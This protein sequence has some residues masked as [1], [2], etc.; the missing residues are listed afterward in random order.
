MFNTKLTLVSHALCPFVQ[1]A[2]IALSEKNVPFD[3]ISIDLDNK[4]DWFLAISPLG[5]VPL[6]KVERAD[7]TEAVIFES[8]VIC[9]YL[10]ETQPGVRIH[11][12]DAVER[13]QHRGW[14]EFGSTILVDLWNFQTTKDQAVFEKTVAA[15]KTKFAR[16]EKELGLGPFFAG[17]HFSF[18]DAAFG[19]IFRQLEVFD[20]G[21]LG[22]LDGLPKVAAWRAALAARPSVVAAAPADY[23]ERLEATV[24]K[25][26]GYLLRA[27]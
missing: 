15:L 19:P 26:D 25:S 13:A 7:G 20:R 18:V 23:R 12:E 27:A 2:A 4:P 10:E 21:N 3:R 6:L 24:Q 11:P 22:I 16:V 8:N 1:R 14:M 17:A 5:K 9:E